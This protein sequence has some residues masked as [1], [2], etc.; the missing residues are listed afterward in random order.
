MTDVFHGR[1]SFPNPVMS[2]RRSRVS[3]NRVYSDDSPFHVLTPPGKGL[4]RGMNESGVEDHY[5]RLYME[6]VAKTECVDLTKN[7]ASN[8]Y[9]FLSCLE[10][11]HVQM[12]ADFCPSLRIPYA[13][14]CEKHVREGVLLFHFY[15]PPNSRFIDPKHMINGLIKA[16][17]KSVF[18]MTVS[19]TMTMR[20]QTGTSGDI[21]HCVFKITEVVNPGNKPVGRL[22]PDIDPKT[23]Y[24][25][26]K[27]LLSPKTFCSASPFH[28][29][30]DRQLNIVQA[31]SS[32]QRV[33]KIDV[34]TK[35]LNFSRVFNIIRPTLDEV[36]FEIFR[37]RPT[38]VFELQI[39]DVAMTP[40]RRNRSQT[41][42]SRRSHSS[43]HFGSPPVSL[44]PD[45][46][47]SLSV[48]S[49]PRAGI[50][51]RGQMFY[52]GESD[53]LLFVGSPV[54]R[55]LHDIDIS[56]LYLSDLAV[57][58]ATRDLIF[59]D[60]FGLGED[61]LE[62]QLRH[63]QEDVEKTGKR[64]EEQKERSDS[65]LRSMLPD[66]VADSLLRGEEVAPK[67]FDDVT[68]LMSDLTNFTELT[69]DWKPRQ[70]VDFLN[71]MY[72]EF[73]MLLSLHEVYKV[74]TVGDSYMVVGGCP[75][76]NLNHAVEVANQAVD[77]IETMTY[78]GHPITGE[79]LSKQL[80]I[81]MHSGVIQ[82]GIVGIER[83]R[84]CLFG[85]VVNVTARTLTSGKGGSITVTESTYA[86]LKNNREFALE[87][88]MLK[89][90]KGVAKKVMLYSLKLRKTRERSISTG[91]SAS[92][93]S[94]RP[95]RYEWM[96][97]AP[98][99]SSLSLERRFLSDRSRAVSCPY[100]PGRDF[101][102]GVRPIR[103]ESE[104][105]GP[106]AAGTYRVLPPSGTA[107]SPAKGGEKG[108][109][110]SRSSVDNK[111]KRTSVTGMGSGV[112]VTVVEH[113][114]NISEESERKPVGLGVG[115]GGSPLERSLSVPL[116][117]QN[118]V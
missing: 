51:I 45:S 57:H 15:A 70:I 17:S 7:L 75:K 44:S 61:S 37:Q 35:K 26:E 39:R 18:N 67:K 20:E 92:M 10:S 19:V 82:A 100:G 64:L 77:M 83:P 25:P 60:G 24:Y 11:I 68:I 115:A 63:V 76:E 117:R 97:Y 106:V 104:D 23:F 71:F 86:K 103:E 105:H 54:V 52:V 34:G 90:M 72:T 50:K 3:G 42:R 84:Y 80:R 55:T 56:G 29:I 59:Q 13:L 116:E 58:D 73:D 93:D 12:Y 88:Y 16:A 38:A 4:R 101:R 8:L 30:F 89:E 112:Q 102:P 87:K 2:G 85:D 40:V 110:S 118:T 49:L 79:L 43:S 28:V 66:P 47:L 21:T 33:L 113:M 111:P 31:G 95:I 9:D 22:Y 91:S 96:S 27:L 78:I 48:E 69:A 6:Q 32:L 46:E 114:P 94:H 62:E 99:S 53:S 5:G 41:P 74:E 1:S 98:T 107:S 108:R 36:S 14:H 109:L 81:G 65:L